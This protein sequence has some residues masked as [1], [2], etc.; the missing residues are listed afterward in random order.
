[1]Y[2]DTIID[3]KRKEV[4]RLKPL[5]IKRYR[6]VINPVT[7]LEKKPF[8]AEFKRSSPSAGIINKTAD[9]NDIIIKYEQGG[10][11]AISILTDSKFFSGSMSYIT[12]ASKI[13][14][15]PILCKDFIIDKIQIQNA[16]SAGADFI[17]LIASI[18][19][20]EE[21]SE[22]TKTARAL[23]MK[24]LFEIHTLEEFK[25]IKKLQPQIVGVNSRNLKTFRIEKNAAAKIIS[26]LKGDFIKVAESGI[27]TAEDILLFHKSGANAFLTGTSLMISDDPAKKLQEFTSVMEETCS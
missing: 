27:E 14:A 15:L 25:K 1:M 4:S 5:Q 3:Y 16:Y 20:V 10:A 21:L 17:L 11:G 2:L 26:E 6:P 12:R 23:E 13:T 22:L 9:I 18:L 7:I 8:I 19:S 24:I